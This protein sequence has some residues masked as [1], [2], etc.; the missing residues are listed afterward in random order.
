MAVVKPAPSDEFTFAQ[1]KHEVLPKIP[2]R[3][4]V[5]GPSGGGKT[6]LLQSMMTSL[7]KTKSGKCP[8]ER[9]FVWSP[10]VNVDP[11]WQPV[12]RYIREKMHVDDTEEKLYFD[13]YRPEELEAVI[14]AQ[15]KILSAQK[16][17]GGK[18]LFTVLLCIDDSLILRPFPD[19][20]LFCA[21]CTPEEG[22]QASRRSPPCNDIG[23]CPL[24]L[25]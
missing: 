8:F 2:F 11:A 6:V 17:R 12:K 7:Y 3:I 21:S 10:S 4:I 23:P 22:T 13:K 24:S 5:A 15:K 18:Q 20:R 9:I 19:A 25:G 14:T 16:K 1:S